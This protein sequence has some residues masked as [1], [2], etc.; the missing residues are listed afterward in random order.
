MQHSGYYK[1]L[2]II[3]LAG[4]L[5]TLHIITSTRHFHHLP[6]GKVVYHAHPLKKD[7]QQTNN[8]HTHLPGEISEF[9]CNIFDFQDFTPIFECAL[10]PEYYFNTKT[11]YSSPFHS[12]IIHNN[13]TLRAPPVTYS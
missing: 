3:L 6:N 4:Y 1:Y 11:H 12:K 10:I 9:Q 13:L 8:K 5:S 2:I 7:N